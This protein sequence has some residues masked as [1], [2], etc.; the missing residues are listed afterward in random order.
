MGAGQSKQS[1]QL[2]NAQPA[3]ESAAASSAA[4]TVLNASAS[5]TTLPPSSPPS[6]EGG[7]GGSEGEGGGCPMKNADGSYRAMPGFASLFGKMPGGHPPVDA[8]KI[9]TA[10]ASPTPPVADESA[11][12]AG[13]CPVK[14]SSRSWNVFRRGGSGPGSDGVPSD[15]DRPTATRVAQQQ[16][17]QQYDVYSRPLPVDPTNNMPV[18]NPSA[19]ARNSLPA[20]QQTVSL[21]TERVSSSIP[22]GGAAPSA[23]GGAQQTTTWT[24][25]SPQMFYNALARKGKLD[26]DTKEEDMESVV[27]IHNCMNEGTWGRILQWEEVLHPSSAGRG[28]S[29]TKFLGRPSDLS[30]KA[31]F[32]HYAL[33]HPLP[34]DRHDWTVTRDNGDGSTEDV[35]YVIDY[36]HDDAAA[37]E[38]DGSGLP[39]MDE[40]IGSGGKLQSLL[41][42]VRPAADGP[43]EVWGRMV[44]MPLMRRGC[45][46]MLECLLFK[47]NGSGPKSDFEPLPLR[48]D[49]SLKN[50][51]GESQAVWE[52]IQ[53][54]AAEKKGVGAKD[55][56]CA[57][58]SLAGEDAK[59][60]AE[61]AASGRASIDDPPADPMTSAVDAAAIAT[62]YS[63]ILSACRE[64]RDALKNCASEEECNRAYM[65]M[66]VCA[67]GHMCPLQHS[68]LMDSLDSAGKNDAAD[69]RI[70]VAMNVL[71][72]CV[73]NFDRRASAAKG[74]F[75][76]EFDDALRGNKE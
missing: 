19:I 59:D 9:D 62:T 22:K 10:S 37:R 43:G 18:A 21:P 47:G 64:S 74:Q 11:G 34:F 46:S 71:G 54:D 30:P 69:A 42:D 66:T 20:P 1:P 56:A 33:G 65:G 6:A 72:E 41:V 73:A 53:K 25:P 15:E 40:G 49:E 24:Y 55:E 68:S 60:V 14:P 35:R 48:P 16:H 8:S 17:Q 76:V 28:P 70:D 32:K 45:R 23:G 13:G 5:P 29:L 3:S 36:Y 75:P 2:P 7:D 63:K 38:E 27:A 67:G 52:S 58:N 31:F 26:A 44:S 57:S 50:T 12:T 51:L 61:I 4:A 39:K